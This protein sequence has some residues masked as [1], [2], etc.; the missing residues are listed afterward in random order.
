MATIVSAWRDYYHSRQG[1]LAHRASALLTV[2]LV[3]AFGFTFYGPMLLANE[4]RSDVVQVVLDDP[5]LHFFEAR[6][7]SLVLTFMI[8]GH[9]TVF[10][11]H[12]LSTPRA[13][14]ALHQAYAMAM[15][16]RAVFMYVTPLKF[17][18]NAPPLVDSLA[19]SPLGY[20]SGAPLRNDLM[21]SGHTMTTFLAA[22]M[23]SELC[24]SPR[25]L[26]SVLA[27]ACLFASSATIA[28]LVILQKA[29]YTVDARHHVGRKAVTKQCVHCFDLQ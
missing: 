5:V 7:F 1:G 18:P 22:L 26:R 21:F 16:L 24:Q 8:Y 14:L 23:Y 20:G 11:L 10:I 28:V 19:Q 15:V 12:A 6:D 13:L 4:S 25:T 3:W 2:P 17:P 9:M 27:Q 29:H